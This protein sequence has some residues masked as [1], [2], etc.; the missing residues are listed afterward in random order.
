MAKTFDPICHDLAKKFS[1]DTES[2]ASI[3]DFAAYIQDCADWWNEE[4][5]ETA[6]RRRDHVGSPKP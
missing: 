2:D 1:P 4:H 6:Q 3:N 5:S